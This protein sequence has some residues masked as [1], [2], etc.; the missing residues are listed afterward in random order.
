MEIGAGVQVQPGH[1][2]QPG[3]HGVGQDVAALAR[4]W[5]SAGHGQA[6]ERTWREPRIRF[7]ESFLF[8][9]K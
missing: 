7:V 6:A 3:L 1:L 9:K 5:L 2:V 8:C 4:A